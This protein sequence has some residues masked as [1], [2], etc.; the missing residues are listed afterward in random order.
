MNV[1]WRVW[2]NIWLIHFDRDLFIFRNPW[3]CLAIATD[4]PYFTYGSAY[5]KWRGIRLYYKHPKGWDIADGG[6][7]FTKSDEFLSHR[8]SSLQ[9]EFINRE[10]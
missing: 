3:F 8:F 5:D 1:N 10:R 4:A 7:I 2:L 9:A 6:F